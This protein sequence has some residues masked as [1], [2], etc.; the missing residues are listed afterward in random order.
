ML[1]QCRMRTKIA[2]RTLLNET[3]QT[4]IAMKRG[5]IAS[6]ITSIEFQKAKV[7]T[8]SIN[9]SITG[10]LKRLNEKPQKALF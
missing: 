6:K 5:P 10:G 9:L 3:Q 7:Y 4:P 8:A 2:E 1:S